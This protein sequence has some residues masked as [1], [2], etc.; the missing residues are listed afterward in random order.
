M[1][2][3]D[4]N[5]QLAKIAAA[6]AEPTRATM[7]C[8]LMDGRARTS[9]ELAMLA[10]VSPSTA[11]VHLSKLRDQSLVQ[12]LAQGKHRYYQLAGA[13]VAAALE[14][15]M[16]IAGKVAPKFSP[17]TP[18]RLRQARTCYDHMAGEYA[19]AIHDYLLHKS[20]LLAQ[21]DTTAYELSADGEQLFVAMGIK[22][23]AL[24][25]GRRRFACACLDWSERRPH[26]GGAVGAALLTHFVQHA[27]VEMDLDSRALQLTSKGR[28]QFAKY[29]EVTVL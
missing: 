1:S 14:S 8:A 28:R 20:Y 13:Q 3:D 15:L 4:I 26:I 27:W 2:A 18:E 12:V 5:I 21:Q 9:T 25:K 22:V 24:R 16:A 19:V 29:F 17:S 6:I 11:S 23:E 10:E 7:L